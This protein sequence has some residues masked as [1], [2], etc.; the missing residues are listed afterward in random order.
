MNEVTRNLFNES[1]NQFYS[2]RGKVDYLVRETDA[3]TTGE[4]LSKMETA[5][6]LEKTMNHVVEVLG[7][8]LSLGDSV[9]AH[10]NEMLRDDV[11]K[12][13]GELLIEYI[14]MEDKIDGLKRDLQD[15]MHRVA[16]RLVEFAKEQT[17]TIGQLTT[18]REF[19]EKMLVEYRE[20]IRQKR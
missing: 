9:R 15:S 7:K 10:R 8:V 19:M 6:E 17:G 20:K 13:D 5:D 2:E 11:M 16:D 18:E 12:T 4:K 1:L 14:D 3:M